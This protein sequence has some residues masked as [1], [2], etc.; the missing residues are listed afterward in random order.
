MAAISLFLYT[1]MAGRDVICKPLIHLD[2]HERR[3]SVP[4]ETIAFQTRT[5]E[6]GMCN[7]LWDT[8]GSIFKYSGGCVRMVNVRCCIAGGVSSTRSFLFFSQSTKGQL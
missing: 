7:E 2:L 5:S 6:Q 3:I 1:N 8:F 4:L